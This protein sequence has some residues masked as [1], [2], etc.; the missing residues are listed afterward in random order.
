MVPFRL[1]SVPFQLSRVPF[2]LTRVPSYVEGFHFNGS[3]FHFYGAGFH[4]YGEGSILTEYGSMF[5]GQPHVTIT[6]NHRA[7]PSARPERTRSCYRENS[8][9]PPVIDLNALWHTWKQ[10]ENCTHFWR[11]WEL[12]RKVQVFWAFLTQ[13]TDG[14]YNMPTYMWHLRRTLVM[15][16]IN[17]KFHKMFPTSNLLA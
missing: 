14:S 5:T 1:S 15:F 11:E 4:L 8:I 3:G 2:L 16:R 12:T 9:V 13:N 7:G 17:T 6:N 10:R